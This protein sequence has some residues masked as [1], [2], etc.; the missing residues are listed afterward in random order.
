VIKISAVV[1]RPDALAQLFACD[2]FTGVGKQDSENTKRLLLEGNPEALLAKFASC[3]IQLES[4]ESEPP[5]C[6]TCFWHDRHPL[7]GGSET[8]L[9]I[10]PA[11]LPQTSLREPVEVG[12]EL[13]I[14]PL[15]T[16]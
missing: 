13:V 8:F 9:S 2:D 11:A 5:S 6:F 3:D 10:T 15:L 14:C 7:R 12:S 1:T 16:A 4:A